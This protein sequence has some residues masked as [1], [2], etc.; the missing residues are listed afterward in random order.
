MRQLARTKSGFKFEQAQHLRVSLAQFPAYSIRRNCWSHNKTKKKT[1]GRKKETH[2]TKSKKSGG[3]D[4][5]VKN[6]R[7]T[8]TDGQ[9]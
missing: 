4:R 3:C 5:D 2:E 9:F 6:P 7:S 1:S 8:S